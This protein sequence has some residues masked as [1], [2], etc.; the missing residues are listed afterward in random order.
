MGSDT[1]KKVSNLCTDI[2]KL[3]FFFLLP[4]GGLFETVSDTVEREKYRSLAP[5]G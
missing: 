4:V 3:H 5:R 2:N 1:A